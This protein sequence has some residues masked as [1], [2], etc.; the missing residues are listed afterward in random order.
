MKTSTNKY[1]LVLDDTKI[2]EGRTL[3]RIRALVAIAATL[4]TPAVAVGDLGGGLQPRRT[5]EAQQ[6]IGKR[7]G[8]A[9]IL[10]GSVRRSGTRVR[11]TASNGR[12]LTVEA[13]EGA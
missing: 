5:V 1:E 8:V 13:V 9:N 2:V 4:A 11:V 7:L 3:C 6:E 10:E 12:D